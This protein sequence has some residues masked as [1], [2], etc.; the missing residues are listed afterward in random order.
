MKT[1]NLE[2]LFNEQEEKVVFFRQEQDGEHIQC[3]DYRVVGVSRNSNLIV[4]K[5]YVSSHTNEPI[6]YTREPKFY[7]NPNYLCSV[8]EHWQPTKN[9][10]KYFIR[11]LPKEF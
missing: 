4:E 11:I 6:H 3:N 9:K 5:N 1:K 7:I 10:P 8:S 2:K